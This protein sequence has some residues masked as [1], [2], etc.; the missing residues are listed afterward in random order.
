M[1]I[2]NLKTNRLEWVN[3]PCIIPMHIINDNSVEIPMTWGDEGEYNLSDT[4][5][6]SYCLESTGKK[7]T[8]LEFT[9]STLGNAVRHTYNHF[10]KTYPIETFEEYEP[11]FF[12]KKQI[13]PYVTAYA[14][15]LLDKKLF[16][17]EQKQDADNKVVYKKVIQSFKNT[18]KGRLAKDNLE[19]L[20]MTYF[21]CLNSSNWSNLEIVDTI[22]ST[23]TV[24]EEFAQM[25]VE[26]TDNRVKRQLM[27]INEFSDDKE[28]FDF[29]M[30]KGTLLLKE[31]A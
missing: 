16:K 7:E 12:I 25:M 20:M 2:K 29:L 4:Y 3:K 1:I 9:G 6:L 18:R 13:Q 10:F 24:N 5:S 11:Y 17:K 19:C 26:S 15:Y 21:Y 30:K 27:N 8:L 22:N 31:G 23:S 14:Y 28:Y